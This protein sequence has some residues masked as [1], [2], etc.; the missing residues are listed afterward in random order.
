[1]TGI[2]AD[3]LATFLQSAPSG[4]QRTRIAPTLSQTE[5]ARISTLSAQL[6]AGREVGD[7]R[8]LKAIF[9]SLTIV[10]HLTL[11][12][13]SKLTGLDVVDIEQALLEPQTLSAEKKY[14]LAVRG[15]YL[16]NAIN[17]ARNC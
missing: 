13:I 6:T 14:Q 10:C 8:R 9:E 12:N 11:L 17:Q 1:M 2:S 15:S 16:I 5:S 4:A 7:D 3:E